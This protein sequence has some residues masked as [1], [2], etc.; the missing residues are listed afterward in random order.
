MAHGVH[1]D[2][3]DLCTRLPQL[4]AMPPCI[5]SIAARLRGALTRFHFARVRVRS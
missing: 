2:H 4:A 1:L 5:R 3:M